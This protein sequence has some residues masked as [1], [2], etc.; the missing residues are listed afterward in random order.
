MSGAETASTKPLPLKVP[1]QV[2]YELAA[3][4]YWG[5]LVDRRFGGTG[6]PFTAFARILT[7]MATVD[8]TVAGLASV[9]LD[10]AFAVFEAAVPPGGL[11]EESRG[12][13]NNRRRAQLLYLIGW[14]H[15]LDP[16][17]R[18]RVATLGRGLG[19]DVRDQIGR[20]HV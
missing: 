9:D 19:L 15:Q 18:S 1:Q 11:I 7:R 12:K 6:T 14:A 20:A 4:G 17:V 13:R 8:P 3:A 2:L 10:G 5:L 16:E